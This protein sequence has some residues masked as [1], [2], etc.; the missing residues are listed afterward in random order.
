MSTLDPKGDSRDSPD[1]PEDNEPDTVASPAGDNETRPDQPA[2]PAPYGLQ[3]S[4]GRTHGEIQDYKQDH[5]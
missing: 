4:P 3:I 5:K 1:T 2:K